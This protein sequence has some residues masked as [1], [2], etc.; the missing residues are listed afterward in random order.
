MEAA[1]HFDLTKNDYT[2]VVLRWRRM[3]LRLRAKAA[4][5]ARGLLLWLLPRPQLRYAPFPYPSISHTRHW[6]EQAESMTLQKPKALMVKHWQ[7]ARTQEPSVY[8][9]KNLLDLGQFRNR[10]GL[11]FAFMEDNMLQGMLAAR[12]SKGLTAQLK[13]DAIQEAQLEAEAAT[14]R[15]EKHDMVRSLIGPKG[16][17]PTLKADLVKLASLLN[18]PVQTGMTVEDLKKACRPLVAEIAQKPTP[19]KA[20]GSTSSTERHVPETSMARPSQAPET[21]GAKAKASPGVT[22]QELQEVLTTQDHKFQG[23]LNQVL[24][25]ISTLHQA[26]HLPG[27]MTS[28]PMETEATM[29]FGWTQDEIQQM[30][31]DYYQDDLEW[32]Q[33]NGIPPRDQ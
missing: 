11:N 32:R 3:L 17:L 5:H 15:G 23:M 30:N 6:Q 29:D 22:A 16:G 19:S 26:S 7:R 18:I 27:P 21:I 4:W 14:K 9:T 12:A 24:Q 33:A 1:Q 25:S 10:A 28:G 13:R 8:T 31:R 20:S 2:K